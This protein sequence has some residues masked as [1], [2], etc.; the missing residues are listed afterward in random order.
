M[1]IPFDV[2]HLSTGSW[3]GSTRDSRKDQRDQKTPQ[4]VKLQTLS[5]PQGYICCFMLT[6]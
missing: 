2:T 3:L 1:M 4:G 5:P 6:N